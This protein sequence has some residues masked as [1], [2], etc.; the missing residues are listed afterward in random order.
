VYLLFSALFGNSWLMFELSPLFESKTEGL[1]YK[2]Q[3][4]LQPTTHWKLNL[5]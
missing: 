5:S 4:Q 3:F 2:T 1:S